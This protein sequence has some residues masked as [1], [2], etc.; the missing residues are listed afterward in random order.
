MINRKSAVEMRSNMYNE[1]IKE[2]FIQYYIKLG[3]S[4]KNIWNVRQ[5]MKKISTYEQKLN[6]DICHMND[7]ELLKLFLELNI[8]KYNSIVLTHRIMKQYI[9]YCIISHK[10]NVT[11]NP[12]RKRII[13]KHIYMMFK[14]DMQNMLLSKSDY[15]KIQ[16]IL[17]NFDNGR[18]KLR[19]YLRGI[20]ELLYSGACVGLKEILELRKS[21]IDV[22]THTIYGVKVKRELIDLLLKEIV[23]IT[24]IE[25]SFR[26]GTRQIKKSHKD[27]IF[28]S[29]SE[30]YSSFYI[31]ICRDIKNITGLD[32]NLSD[33]YISGLLQYLY[34]HYTKE[35]GEDIVRDFSGNSYHKQI[36]SWLADK[37]VITPVNTFKSRYLQVIEQNIHLLKDKW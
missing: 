5:I 3:Y 15:Q 14:D 37:N 4:E 31:S 13:P 26:T 33:I 18:K 36:Q 20:L 23:E 19:A 25:R 35:G 8:N 21:D 34:D 1:N 32:C 9:D 2:E 29:T 28:G 22:D 10:I 16:T 24:E 27:C 6:L 11:I 7:D 17:E 30:N 12:L